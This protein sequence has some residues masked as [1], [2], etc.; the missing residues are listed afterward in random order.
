MDTMLL[1]LLL[2]LKLRLLLWLLLKWMLIMM[3]CSDDFG[4]GIVV[5]A[6][7]VALALHRSCCDS[8]SG[9]SSR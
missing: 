7:S 1:L 4:S 8:S 5:G 6:G 2:V 3:M 9:S